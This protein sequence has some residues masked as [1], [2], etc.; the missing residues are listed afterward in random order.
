[1]VVPILSYASQV[2]YA[3]KSGLNRI[4][5]LQK[6]ASRW[7]LPTEENYA[8]RLSLLKFLPV[9]LYLELHD[10]M[11]FSNILKDRFDIEWQNTFAL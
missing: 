6:R 9:S 10:V 7:I 11:L 1:M 4:E 8:T 5:M 3:S 2:W